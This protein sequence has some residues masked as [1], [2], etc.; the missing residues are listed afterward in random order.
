MLQ[1]KQGKQRQHAVGSSDKVLDWL[2]LSCV[3]LFLK[4]KWHS[5]CSLDMKSSV[6]SVW[7]FFV[8][9]LSFGGFFF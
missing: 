7:S 8:V 6:S 1:L 2:K 4:V 9:C 5:F 3:I